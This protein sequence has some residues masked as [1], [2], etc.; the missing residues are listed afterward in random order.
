[1]KVCYLNFVRKTSVK[2]LGVMDKK[3]ERLCWELAILIK[4]SNWSYFNTE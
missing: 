1:M 3:V 4:M 2:W